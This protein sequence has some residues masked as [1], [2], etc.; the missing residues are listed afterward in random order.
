MS[1]DNS[2]DPTADAL[3]NPVRDLLDVLDLQPA[4]RAQVSPEVTGDATDADVSERNLDVFV[5]RSQVTPHGRVFGGQVLAQSVMA[6]GRTVRSVEGLGERP[7]HSLH[8]YFIRPGDSSH[9]IRFAVENLRDGRSFSVRRVHAMQYGHTIL[10]A[11][12]SFQTPADGLDHQAAMNSVPDPDRVRTAAE[13]LAGVD[14][15]AVRHWLRR[16]MDVRTVEGA[17]Y[18]VP[19]RQHS[20]HQN[21]WMKAIEQLPD[22]PLLHAAVLAYSSDYSLLESILR[23]HGLVWGDRRLRPASLDHAMW[24]HRPGRIDDWVLYEQESPSASGG[25]GLGLGKI[26]SIDG[27]LICSV[28]QEGMV[29]VKQD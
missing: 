26:F 8:A 18:L 28:A 27:T 22:D 5:G 21:V 23:R 13:E 9:P 25:R 20:A 17:L 6:G 19:G 24:F 3:D 2:T 14:H 10:S 12:L 7:I 16:A 4:G 29:R 11:T 1:D 15:P